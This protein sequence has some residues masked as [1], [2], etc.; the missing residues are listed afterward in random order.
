MAYPPN[1][2]AKKASSA[3]YSIFWV[4]SDDANDMPCQCCNPLS[5]IEADFWVCSAQGLQWTIVDTPKET[6][7][8]LNEQ[9]FAE[10]MA[11]MTAPEKAMRLREEMALAAER[12]LTLEASRMFSY[13]ESQKLLNMRGKGKERHIDKVDEPCKF[14]YCDEKAPKSMWTTNAKGERCAP[15]RKELTGSECWAHMYHHPKTK[16]LM[17]PRT[18]KRLHPGEAGWREEWN[19]NRTFRVVPPSKADNFFAARMAGGGCLAE[20]PKPKLV[21]V[22]KAKVVDNSGW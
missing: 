19:L 17:T 22:R 4:F 11:R 6:W 8:D 21:F 14:L 9:A 16:A 15:L 20:M 5:A 3:A 18:C 7:G 1:K 13:A 10:D 2:R 12:G